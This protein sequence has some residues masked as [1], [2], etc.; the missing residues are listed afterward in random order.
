MKSWVMFCEAAADH[1]TAATLIDEILALRGSPWVAAQLV[2]APDT[3][4]AWWPDAATFDQRPWFDLHGLNALATKLGIRRSHGHF[5][6]APTEPGARMVDTIARVVRRMRE[7]GAPLEAVVLVWDMDRDGTARRSGLTQGAS[8]WNA[9][10]H[11]PLA[12]V[13]ACPDPMREA[14]VL[15]GFE[16]ETDAELTRATAL[17]QQL[18]VDPVLHAERLDASDR[19][20]S[21]HPKQALHA[22]GVTTWERERRCL[23]I[24]DEPALEG[25]CDRGA[26]IGLADFLR[27]V[28]ATLLP[29]VDPASSA[30]N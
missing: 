12:L 17:R 24:R 14:W 15:A 10:G 11:T 28:I 18:G 30:R 7:G 26:R 2:D 19:H 29:L 4:R 25:L 27:A 20:A 21:K 1:R 6:G 8:Q 3:V 16:P 9:G 13:L 23:A 22:L 5:Q